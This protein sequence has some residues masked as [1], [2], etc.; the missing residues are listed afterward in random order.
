MRALLIN[1]QYTFSFWSFPENCHLAGIK[2]V[3]PPLGLITLAALLPG[4][5]ELKLADLNIEAVGEDRWKWADLIMISG[6]LGHGENM[7]LLIKEAKRRRKTVVAGGPYTTMY[8]E[9]VLAAG[10]DFVVRGEAEN[11]IGSLIQALKEGRSQGIFQSDEK[12]DMVLSPIPRYDLLRMHDYM[13]ISIQT[14]RGCLYQCEF[15][16]IA[17]LCGPKPRYKTP[18]QVMKE[19]ETIYVLGWRGLILVA[20]DNFIGNRAHV[21][22]LLERLIPWNKQRSQP[23]AFMTQA[24]IELGMDRGLIDLLTAAN[25]GNIFIGIESTDL[26]VL[27]D[28]RKYHNLRNPM[29]RSIA[30]INKNGLIVLGSFILGFDNEKQGVHK[31]ICDFVEATNIP[32][33]MINLLLAG[34]GTAMWKRLLK[35][36]RIKYS[37]GATRGT[38]MFGDRMNFVPKRPESEIMEEYRMACDYLYEPSRFLARTYRYFLGMRPTRRALGIKADSPLPKRHVERESFPA[39]WRKVRGVFSL[40]WAQGVRP[41][42]RWQFWRQLFSIYR[43]NPSR[44]VSYLLTCSMGEDLFRIREM[45]NGDV[46]KR[47]RAGGCGRPDGLC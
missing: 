43:R 13:V 10:A 27:R 16:D 45:L 46:A 35:E 17:N 36:G 25:F 3:A 33:V 9:E 6:M 8:T 18:G 11:T 40:A 26:D 1:P 22:R 14:S 19:L 38:R 4:D 2:A 37:L 12:P 31:R 34:T 24:S 44:I 29:V 20:D 5:W 7:P 41:D 15:C 42:Y 21:L 47:D 32:F 28:S 39:R 23:F 30:N